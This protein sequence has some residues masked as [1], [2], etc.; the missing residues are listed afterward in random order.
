VDNDGLH[1]AKEVGGEIALEAGLHSV[2][3]EFFQ[4]T[5]GIVL[6]VSYAGPGIDKQSFP[7][8]ACFRKK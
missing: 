4:R 5:G 7:A 3:I 1:G 6:D 2:T 8:D